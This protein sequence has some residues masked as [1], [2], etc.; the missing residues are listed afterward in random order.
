MARKDHPKE[1]DQENPSPGVIGGAALVGACAGA[2]ISGPLVAI[3]LG[4]AGAAL[5]LRRDQAREDCK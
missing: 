4:A 3:G 5:T 2:L 1:E